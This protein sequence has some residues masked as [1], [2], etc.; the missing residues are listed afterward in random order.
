MTIPDGTKVVVTR[1]LG[2]TPFGLITV[3]TSSELIFAPNADGERRAP[4]ISIDL[5]RSLDLH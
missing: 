5:S 1:S 3:P 4:S 2:V